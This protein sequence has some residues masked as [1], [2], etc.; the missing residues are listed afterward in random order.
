VTVEE[1]IA[2]TQRL[3]SAL[4]TRDRTAWIA[5]FDPDLE[6]YSGLVAVEGGVPFEGLDGAGEWFDNLFEVYGGLRGS[7]DQTI[8][9]GEL[10][11]QLLRVEYVGK[12]SG[13]KLAPLVAWVIKIRDGRYSYVH[14]H[15]DLAEGFLD[16][17]RRLAG[18]A[19][20]TQD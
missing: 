4:N 14:S 11:L 5:C 13:V 2:L 1:A 7:L 6:G 10:A 8:V 16:M 20:P 19:S 9:V 17:S 18:R 12:G 3:L 15:F